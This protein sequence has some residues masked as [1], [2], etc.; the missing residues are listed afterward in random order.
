M[1]VCH[2]CERVQA[3]KADALA[4]RFHH[5]DSLQ[6]APSLLMG[7]AV[8]KEAGMSEME[9][10]RLTAARR[11]AE[12]YEGDDSRIVD[13]LNGAIAHSEERLRIN[14]GLLMENAELRRRIHE[15]AEGPKEI[16][17]DV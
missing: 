10:E 2:C 12:G 3:E 5:R 11:F 8:Q 13:V 15:L 16:D 7:S 14:V 1:T 4:Q 17:K 6:I 9:D